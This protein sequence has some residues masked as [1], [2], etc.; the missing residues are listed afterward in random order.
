MVI[1]E[2]LIKQEE[3]G[4]IPCSRFDNNFNYYQ[5]VYYNKFKAILGD[6]LAV[7]SNVAEACCKI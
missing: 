6:W 4:F 3:Q 7:A 5:T 1:L 2:M